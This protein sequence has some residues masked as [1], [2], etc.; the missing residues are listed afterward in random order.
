VLQGFL[1]GKFVF[2][3]EKIKDS[4]VEH[5]PAMVVEKWIDLIERYKV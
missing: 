2:D 4:V 3:E 5:D 1:E